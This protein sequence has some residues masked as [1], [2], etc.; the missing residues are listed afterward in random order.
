MSAD[1]I[2]EMMELDAEGG[3]GWAL[4]RRRSRSSGR[5]RPGRIGGSTSSGSSHRLERAST[6][7]RRVRETRW[8][9]A[10][11][12]GV[13][14]S[15]FGLWTDAML[16]ATDTTWWPFVFGAVFAGVVALGIAVA[17]RLR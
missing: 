9:A 12:G 17:R 8:T 5:S 14:A 6:N 1:A 11:L 15:L 2:G 4:E 10:L 16:G 13:T 3:T 7:V